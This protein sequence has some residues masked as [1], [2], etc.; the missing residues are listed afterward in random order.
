M[1]N[2]NITKKDVAWSYVAKFFQIGTGFITLPLVLH[3]LT[4]EEVGMNYLMMTISSIIGLLDFG[5]SPQ[6]GRNFTYVNS[7]ARRLLKEG[8]EYSDNK[9]ID[10]HLLSILLKT[11]RTVYQRLSIFSVALMLTAGT[12]Y[13]YYVTKGFT[14]VNNVLPI[15]LLFCLTS[16]FNIYFSY[17][18]SLLTG[19][20]KIA[21]ANKAAIYS[22]SA[23]LIICIPL[24]LLHFGLFSIIIANFISPFVSR[25][26]SYHVYFTE[27]L[28]SILD[29]NI[30]KQ[31]VSEMFDVIWYNAKKLGINF[32]GS[33]AINKSAM[34]I[35]GFYLPLAVVGSYGLL[36]QLTTVLSGVAQIMFAT[37]SPRFSN[38]RVTKQDEEFKM[39]MG[40][41]IGVYWI[42]MIIG[43]I[44]ILF[45]A[46]PVLQ[47][48]GSKT[49]LPSIGVCA[50]YLLAITLEG[51]HSDFATLIVTG[52]KVPFVKPS[53]LSG[54][55]ILGFTILEL[56][57]TNFGLI[58][59]VFVQ[60]I[61]QLAYSNWRW[62]KWVMDEFHMS[63]VDFFKYSYFAISSKI[64]KYI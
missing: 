36:I 21:E 26:Y 15:W 27:E 49:Q 22:K 20:G 16:Y 34:F 5:F 33:Y 12:G 14:N 9:S 59:V 13:I 31:E 42:M 35:I 55:F 47:L 60:F 62:P 37:Y 38:L 28:V 48:I 51:N 18:N 23:Y 6:F 25:Y 24:L 19:S 41:T 64:K 4:P 39:L 56:Q 10:Y 29:K 8:V 58:G 53:I 43:S 7:G 57:F 3:L 40:L 46:P 54:L 32:V 52:N 17:Y 45:G 63:I 44:V 2:I 50:L 30:I 1:S 61:V 11:A